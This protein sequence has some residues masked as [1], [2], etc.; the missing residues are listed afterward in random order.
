MKQALRRAV[1]PSVFDLV[2]QSPS[3]NEVCFL[4]SFAEVDTGVTPQTKA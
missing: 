3:L 1:R 2:S 4:G